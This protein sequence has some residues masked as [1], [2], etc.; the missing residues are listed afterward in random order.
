M[1]RVPCFVVLLERTISVPIFDVGLSQSFL[2]VIN[3]KYAL[4]SQLRCKS[5]VKTKISYIIK[6]AFGRCTHKT[7]L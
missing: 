1:K 4:R 2:Q 3:I 7:E 6:G 5:L